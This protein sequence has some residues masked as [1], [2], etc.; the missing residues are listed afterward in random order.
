M[1]VSEHRASRKAKYNSKQA[2]P[3]FQDS[4]MGLYG[5]YRCWYFYCSK[6]NTPLDLPKVHS[7][8]CQFD[9]LFG[10]KKICSHLFL[11]ELW[12][13]NL[14]GR[15]C[16]CCNFQSFWK[17]VISRIVFNHRPLRPYQHC[18][19]YRPNRASQYYTRQLSDSS[20]MRINDFMCGVKYRVAAVSLS[21]PRNLQIW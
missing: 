7:F 20:R 6:S 4:C 8:F 21:L 9:V 14:K 10:K 18:T 17:E 2:K 15:L 13:G 11:G 3:D 5:T 1:K 16:V 19:K 12:V